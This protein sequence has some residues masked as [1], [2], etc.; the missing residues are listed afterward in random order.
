MFNRIL[1]DIT[2]NCNVH[3]IQLCQ[4]VNWA[5]DD[6]FYTKICI[7]KGRLCQFLNWFEPSCGSLSFY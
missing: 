4:F 1:D 2:S 6:A 5:L 7:K 3:L